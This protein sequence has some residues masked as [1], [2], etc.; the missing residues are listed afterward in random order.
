M[1]QDIGKQTGFEFLASDAVLHT[2]QPVTISVKDQLISAVLE[3]IFKTQPLQYEIRDKII[4]V[5]KK[6]SL[7][8]SPRKDQKTNTVLKGKIIDTI[9]NPL[10]GATITNISRNFSTI[11]SN[12]GEFEIEG[13]PG[14]EI[15]ISFI[16]FL[17]Y[18][19]QLNDKQDYLT[20]V[21]KTGTSTLNEVSV[22]STGY[23]TIPKERI[24]GSFAQPL[25]NEYENRVAPDVISKLNGIT[26]GLVFNANT[27]TTQSGK[28]DINIR[29]RSTIFANDQPLVV[30]DNFPYSGDINNIN[31]NDVESISVLKDAAAASIWGVRA[32][33]GVIVITTRKGKN[34]QALKIEFNANLTV[35]NKPDLNYNPNQLD[36]SSYISLEQFL[37]SK[38][39]YD[40]SLTNTS[41][42]PVISPVVSL[43]AANRAGTL[44]ANDLNAQLNVLRNI[45][46]KDQLNKYFYQKATNQQY[47]INLSGGSNKANY[48]FSSGYDHD[49]SSVKDNS[50]QRFTLNSQNTFHVTSKLE[51]NAGINYIRTNNQFDNTLTQTARR[52]FPYSQIADNNG[53][54][55]PIPYNYNQSFIQNAIPSGFLDWS[56]YPL[57]ELGAT[58]NTTNI[59]DTRIT[60]GLKYN[61]IPGL[62][63]E[64]K[65]Q[66]ENTLS[67]NRIYQSQDTYATRDYINTFSIVNNGVVTG[68]NVPLGGILNLS[69]GNT[70][71]NNV[72]GQ[73]NYNN[74]WSDN[75]LVAILGYELSQTTGQSNQSILYGYNDD[76]ATFSNIDAIDSFNTYPSGSQ[77]INSGLGVQSTTIRVR[78][79]FANIAYN[80]KDRYTISG[81]ARIDGTNYFGVSTNK[82]NLPL[83]SA[84]FK[85]DISREAF[86]KLDWLPSLALRTSYGYNGNLIQSITGITTFQYYSNATYTN[87]NYALI[88]NIGNPDLRWEKTGIANIG[89][90]FGTKNGV[91]TGS[92]EYYFKRESDLL[93]FKNFPENSGITQLEGNFSNMKGSGYDLSI[94]TQ[95]IKGRLKW[96]TTFLL[97]HA[98]DKVTSYDVKPY[99]YQL[100][101]AGTGAPNINRPVFGVYAYKWGGLDPATGNP[102][103]SI[104]GSASQDYSAITI[105]TPVEDLIYEGP[106][107][108]TYFGGLNN[109]F[110][111]RNFKL[112][113]QVN[114]KLGY[115]FMAPALNYST[116]ITSGAY[117]RVNNQFNDRWQVP[118]DEKR[119]N[120]PSLIYPFS[121]SRDQFYKYSEVNVESGDHIRLQDI[122]LSY[123][124]TKS[125]FHS[126]PFA[127]L[128]LS[129]YANNVG[130]IW[131]KNNRGLD[132]DAVP[133]TDNTTMPI[134]RSISIGLKGNF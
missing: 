55:L 83:W 97:S 91:I 101:G 12:S 14:D 109:S 56:Y 28:L 120:V 23:Q 65:Y 124:F 50:N 121:S 39:F 108:P 127:S 85:W 24:T 13:R 133:S 4:V 6:E 20:I 126:L 19:F 132:P 34:N 9:G 95:N 80:Y 57:K 82:K 118:G 110:S 3:T 41:S 122:T 111:F 87:Y 64:V 86:Y 117:L 115:Y 46:V 40:A 11:T 36:A 113:F 61:L 81:S 130:I 42:Y 93:G 84:G 26:S 89:L 119:T 96:N 107:R 25:K 99:S 29:G 90:D 114:Y 103:G 17:P 2:S 76:L 116:I 31:P 70:T 60:A 38:G 45:N 88:S 100:A 10:P 67:D 18:N 125:A 52:V 37:F 129:I 5:T 105:N 62:S 54:S 112:T 49:L 48:Y 43:L 69:R 35:F 33:N 78:S 128:Q 71:S 63:A 7:Q 134:P 58:D 131:R 98:T 32:G 79:S 68:Y 74:H 104:K 72:R 66:Y 94:T 102:I 77:S 59:S 92:L 44:S 73:F 27:L 51:V 30:V 47:A 22:V 8:T 21:L 1:F 15:S 123:D 106:A 16:G 53:N 75:D